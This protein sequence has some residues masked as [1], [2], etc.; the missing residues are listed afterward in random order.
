MVILSYERQEYVRRQL[1]YY[2]DKPLHIVIADGS[3]AAWRD[4]TSGTRGQMT[5]EYFSIP[6]FDTYEQRL[7]A[8]VERVSTEFMFLIDDQECILWTGLIRASDHLRRNPDHSCA[9]GRVAITAED[10][11]ELR[12]CPWGRWSEPWSLLDASP[13]A[14]FEAMVRQER[15]ANLFYQLFRTA[16]A[17]TYLEE[18]ADYRASYIGAGELGPT[19]FRVLSG[20]WVMGSYPFWLRHGESLSRPASAAAPM[21]DAEICDMVGRL[22]TL[23]SQQ[24]GPDARGALNSDYDADDLSRLISAKWGRYGDSDERTKGGPVISR[25][26]YLLAQILGVAANALK[27]ACPCCYSRLN[28]RRM[29]SHFDRTTA[30]PTPPE[31]CLSF[32]DYGKAFGDGRAEVQA[33]LLLIKQIW[34]SFPNGISIDGLP[35]PQ[36]P[37]S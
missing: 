36:P 35:L 28:S 7:Q 24:K 16:N 19:A 14:R 10:R 5:W 23:T 9:G 22:M 4:G 12:L 1:L 17:Q 20:K 32:S 30:A 13:L 31:Q 18:F 15:T 29:T 25:L 21:S 27:F 3:V 37:N 6:G 11:R 34:E 2:A 26:G 8:A 33:D